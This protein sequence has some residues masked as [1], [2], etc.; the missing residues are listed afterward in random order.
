M[1]VKYVSNTKQLNEMKISEIIWKIFLSKPYHLDRF[2]IT[3]LSHIDFVIEGEPTDS[4][5]LNY[6][7]KTRSHQSL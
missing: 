3:R 6:F 2:I 7:T 4:N 5:K 1:L